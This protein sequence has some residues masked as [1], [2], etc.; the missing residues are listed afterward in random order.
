MQKTLPA[1]RWEKRQVEIMAVLADR[2]GGE[3]G[4]FVQ[5]LEYPA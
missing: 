3:G 4:N 1:A 5:I 2:V